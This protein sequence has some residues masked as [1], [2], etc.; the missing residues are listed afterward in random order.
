MRLDL[1]SHTIITCLMTPIGARYEQAYAQAHPFDKMIEGM[2]QPRMLEG[3]VKIMRA[4]VEQRV[5][6][7]ALIN[8]RA[9][10]NAPSIAQMLARMFRG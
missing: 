8:N 7:V 1:L 4:A 2:M 9:G 5:G 3:A 10:G 6:A